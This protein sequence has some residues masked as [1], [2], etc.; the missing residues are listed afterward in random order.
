MLS[1]DKAIKIKPDSINGYIF[2]AHILSQLERLE[3]A[4]DNYKIAYNIN[5][6]HPFL[7]G[8]I[9]NTKSKCCDWE[10]FQK[11]I[12]IIKLNLENEKKISYPYK[13]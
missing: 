11:D 5:S 7:L 6:E 10:N 12:E 3:E 4:L 1:Y 2:K 13:I 9:V 8:Y